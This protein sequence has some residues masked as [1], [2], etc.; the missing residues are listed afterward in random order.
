MSQE[1][2]TEWFNQTY[3]K[4]GLNYLRPKEAY[5]IFYELLKV[6]K[7][8]NILDV[9]CGPGQMLSV[10][11]D[12]QLKKFGIDISAVAIEMA[13]QKLPDADVRVA[14]AE[15]LPFEDNTFDYISCLGSLERMIN[16]E[17]ALQEQYRVAKTGAK[18]CYMVR[19]SDRASWKIV[20]EKLG[21]INKKGHQGAKSM[22]EWSNIFEK[23]G[24]T[25]DKIHHDQWPTVR[26]SR[27]MSLNGALKNVN[28]KKI[29][30]TMSNIENAYEFIFILSKP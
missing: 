25:I 7:G 1:T 14:N 19:N 6:E 28:Y 4:R 11:G 27:W 9:A 17:K 21:V 16:L 5:Y 13:K 12:Y 18:M 22:K 2:I 10:A 8:K 26:W 24:F 15:D 23:I 20:K 30:P 29:Q 3:A